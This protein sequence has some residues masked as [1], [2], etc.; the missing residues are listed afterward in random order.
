MDGPSPAP[1]GIFASLKRLLTTTLAVA[2]NRLELF[3]VE[4]R[5]ERLQ[6]FEV[7]LLAGIVLVLLAMTLAVVTVAVVALCLRANR[8][9]L[10]LGLILLYSLLTGAA[11]WRLRKRLKNWA[12]FSATLAELKKDKACLA[13]KN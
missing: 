13:E 11:F 9:D 7:L 6:F 1:S 3:F 2:H 8:F 4:L 10:V 5:E 12:P